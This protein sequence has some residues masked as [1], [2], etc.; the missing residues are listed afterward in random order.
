[1][2]YPPCSRS[3]ESFKVPTPMTDDAVVTKLKLFISWVGWIVCIIRIFVCEN[4]LILLTWTSTCTHYCTGVSE[5]VSHET[6]VSHD[7]TLYSYTCISNNTLRVCVCVCV[8]VCV[9]VC[10]CACV[11]VSVC[12]CMYVCIISI[13]MPFLWDHTHLLQICCDHVGLVPVPSFGTRPLEL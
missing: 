10:V 13:S 9:R 2:S 8:C 1:M 4:V 12:V 11:C 5:K 7:E 3:M 6:I